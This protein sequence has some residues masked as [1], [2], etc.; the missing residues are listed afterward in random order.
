MFICEKVLSKTE[1]KEI[2]NSLQKAE[3]YKGTSKLDEQHK[4]NSEYLDENLS[5]FVA[6]KIKRHPEVQGNALMTKLKLPMFNKYDS[7]VD[8]NCAI[9]SLEG[10]VVKSTICSPE[11]K[12][13][14]IA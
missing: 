12:L 3:W 14:E 11:G 8:T 13:I 10:V 4:D 9:I 5:N 2:T 1:V 7:T 6:D